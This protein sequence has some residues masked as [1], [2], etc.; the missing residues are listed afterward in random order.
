MGSL[1]RLSLWF[2]QWPS[3]TAAVRIASVF[4]RL[5]VLCNTEAAQVTRANIKACFPEIDSDT[6]AALALDSLRH[7]SLLFFEFAQLAHWHQDKLLDQIVEINGKSFLDDAY[8]N[9]KG[10]ILLVPHFGNWELLCA[11]LGAHYNF[12]ALY[13]PPKIASIEQV[14]LDARQR[15]RGEMFPIA[16]GG[17]RS[18]L[19]VLKQGRLAAILPDQVPDRSAGVY[20]DFFGQPALTMT[21]ISRMVRKDAPNVLVGSVERVLPGSESATQGRGDITYPAY[22]LNFET[23]PDAIEGK[24]ATACATAINQAIERVVAR[25]PA[26]YQWEYKRFKRPPQSRK[27]SIY[28]RQ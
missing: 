3:Q 16:T 15:F 8:A 5:L 19:K 25:A 22:R 1:F 23:L 4:A 12:A 10:V 13:D 11:F 20:A 2:A 17:M 27:S 18:I 6:Q 9:G 14:I 7:M 28:R 21:L 24:D 26:Q